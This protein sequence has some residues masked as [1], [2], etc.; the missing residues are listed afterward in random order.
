M[1]WIAPTIIVYAYLSKK[2]TKITYLFMKRRYLITFRY[3]TKYSL[4]YI[5]MIG[6]SKDDVY[7]RACAMYGFLNVAGVHVY[8]QENVDAL[9][10]KNFREMQ[11]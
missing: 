9:H 6:T 4:R 3:N 2:S 5:V 11:R 1:C 7:G 10:V 8:T